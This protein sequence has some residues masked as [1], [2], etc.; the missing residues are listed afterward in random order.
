MLSTDVAF[1]CYDQAVDQ[2]DELTSESDPEISPEGQSAD[3]IDLSA[4][5]QRDQQFHY[6]IP[7][8]DL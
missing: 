6:V 8:T 4:L 2:T 3:V 7:E 1:G 5:R